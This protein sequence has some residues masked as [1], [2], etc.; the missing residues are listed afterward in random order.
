M[1]FR[2]ALMTGIDI[3]IPEL[4]L[5]IHQPTIKEISYMGESDFFTGLHCL[6]LNKRTMIQDESLLQDMTNFQILMKVL[7]QSDSQ[8]KKTAIKTLLSLL[9]PNYKA[10]LTP[11]S[12]IFNDM[13]TKETKM[14]DT[15]NFN[16]L[17]DIIN[18]VLCTKNLLQ[19]NKVIYN[20]INDKAKEIAN[21]LMQGRQKVAEIKGPAKES[22]L[23]KYLSILTV[24]LNSMSLEH[25]VNLTLYQ[26]LDLIER[27]HL[28]VEWD[29]DLRVRLAGGTPKSEPENWMK[30][31]H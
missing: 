30:D 4:Q 28:Y 1:D 15:N 27:Y 16:Y 6:C 13:S 14:V 3:P 20:P 31:I 22:V 5:T 9:F 12:I 7:E 19:G 18:E 24:G 25:C 29:M 8:E 11:N 2:L 10:M 23:G 26:L 17:Q 21:K